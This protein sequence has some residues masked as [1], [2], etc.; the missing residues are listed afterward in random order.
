MIQIF[1][2]SGAGGFSGLSIFNFVHLNISVTNLQ[3]S[4]KWVNVGG[5]AGGGQQKISSTRASLP[6]IT[7]LK[8]SEH[9][10]K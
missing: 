8:V 10:R 2:S 7:E 6:I 3:V 1:K 4:V 9:R 5:I